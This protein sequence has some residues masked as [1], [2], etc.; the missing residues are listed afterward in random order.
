MA[1][2]GVTTTTGSSSLPTFNI[3]GLASGLDTNSIITQLM[4]IEQQPQQRLQL[5]SALEQQRVT[6]LTAIKT[7]LQ[8]LSTAAAA[9]ADPGTWTTRATIVSSNPAAVTATGTAPP[10]GFTIGVANLARAAQ[11]TQQSSLTAAATDDTLHVRIGGADSPLATFD[12]VVAKGDTLATIA[13]K[14]NAVS[15][16]HL[17]AA[18]VNSKLVLTG[19]DTGAANTIS[20]TSTGGGTVAADLGLT[21]SVAPLDATYTLDGDPTP[22]HSASNTLTNVATGLNVTL[23]GVTSSDAT[24][25]V[26]ASGPNTSAVEDALQ[27]FVSAYNATIDL[28]DAKVNEQKVANPQSNADRLQ[29]DLSAD[30]SLL[31][32]LSQL[33]NAVTSSFAGAANGMSTLSQAGL[34]TGAAVG[35][36]TLD[37]NSI[38]GDLT[39]DTSKL[40]DALSSRFDDVKRLFTN[41]GTP[42]QFGLAQRLNAI[43]LGTTGVNG[44]LTS[45]I[46]GE[47]DLVTSLAKQSADWDVR[48]QD[49]EAALRQQFSDMETALS[50]L[51]TQ[52]NWLSGQISSLASGG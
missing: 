10:G 32:V 30:P 42:D 3:G 34:S 37:P 46:A 36:G 45:E 5:Q 19:Q 41:G 48:L 39:L 52:G 9:L 2:A 33:R 47:N 17:S 6:D 49:K 50:K 8:S 25:S 28:I 27:S 16:G 18:V 15:G 40:E 51:Q 24:I 29:G 44:T 26:G 35:T 20:V 4:S 23:Q 14:T 1:T 11:L 22:L 12:V 43:A 21:Q 38:R 13:A 7:Q 31:S